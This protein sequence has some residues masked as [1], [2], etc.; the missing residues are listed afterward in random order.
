MRAPLGARAC[1]GTP[2]CPRALHTR[3][4]SVEGGESR[5]TL[6]IVPQAVKARRWLGR[7]RVRGDPF[8]L[9]C[10]PYWGP[11]GGEM[12]PRPVKYYG[13]DLAIK[14][15]SKQL[16]TTG[17]GRRSRCLHEPRQPPLH[18]HPTPALPQAPMSCRSV[19]P[20]RAVCRFRIDIEQISASLSRQA[21]KYSSHLHS[22]GLV[23]ASESLRQCR[24]GTNCLLL[25]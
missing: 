19:L 24:R 4:C 14:L 15:I 1:A 2:G 25:K 12:T 18:P 10:R 9:P 13:T 23:F 11:R 6:R 22:Q 20:S 8:T 16:I 7:L 17:V 21:Y 3:Q 5:W